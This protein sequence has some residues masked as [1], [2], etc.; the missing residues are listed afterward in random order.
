MSTPTPKCGLLSIAFVHLIVPMSSN[1]SS[2][3]DKL[4]LLLG[5]NHVTSQTPLT[6][7]SNQMGKETLNIYAFSPGSRW[8]DFDMK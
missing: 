8:Y 5:V 7:S 4:I 3:R 6:S 2:S 1:V